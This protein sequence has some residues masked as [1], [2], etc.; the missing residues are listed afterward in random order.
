MKNSHGVASKI[1]GVGE[2]EIPPIHLCSVPRNRR[3]T[4]SERI[5]GSDRMPAHAYKP[6]PVWD[7]LWTAVACVLAMALFAAIWIAF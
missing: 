1:A 5:F 6:H 2:I 3:K 4:L 7:P